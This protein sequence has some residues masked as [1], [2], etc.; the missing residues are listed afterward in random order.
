MLKT[1]AVGIDL[2]MHRAPGKGLQDSGIGTPV[3]PRRAG[4]QEKQG[5]G[6]ADAH[7]IPRP[8]AING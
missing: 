4:D 8:A 2:G 3:R 5:Q 6:P 7:S 1:Q